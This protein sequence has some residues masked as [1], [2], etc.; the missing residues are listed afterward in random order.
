MKNGCT[1]LRPRPDGDGGHDGKMS[2]LCT[3]TKAGRRM[4]GPL[5]TNQAAVRLPP[6]LVAS[7][8]LVPVSGSKVLFQCVLLRRRGTD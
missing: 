7:F 8:F 4:S 1:L 2:K 6:V 3:D 5:T